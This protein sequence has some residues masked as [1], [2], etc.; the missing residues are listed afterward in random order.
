MQYY[1]V[2]DVKRITGCEQNKSYEIIR[3]L[4]KKFRKLYP[5]AVYI[6]GKVMKWFFDETMGIERKDKDEK[7]KVEA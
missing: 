6:Q 4:N 2:E 7:Y 1:T 3:E 5:N